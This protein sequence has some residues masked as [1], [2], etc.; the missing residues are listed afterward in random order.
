MSRLAL[1]DLLVTMGREEE[2]P[3]VTEAALEREPDH[4]G[5]KLFAGWVMSV[6]RRYGRA[7]DEL[8]AAIAASPDRP[9]A[10]GILGLTY[11]E[12]GRHPEAIAEL[13]R[14][15]ELSP[16]GR[17]RDAA[18]VTL[19][20]ALARAGEEARARQIVG[21][22]AAQGERCRVPTVLAGFH[23]PPGVKDEGFAWLER[24]CDKRCIPAQYLK[25]HPWF[26]GV[27]EDPRFGAFLRRLGLDR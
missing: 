4:P 22:F 6:S 27:R 7:I 17:D 15:L 2:A 12:E 10:H 24:A 19:A 1:A 16:G 11:L 13:E 14:S 26:D 18:E 8:C 5:V 21:G 25:V 9:G 20:V 23:I 3:S